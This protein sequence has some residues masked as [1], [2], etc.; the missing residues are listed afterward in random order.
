[1]WKKKR[2]REPYGFHVPGCAA[3]DAGLAGGNSQVED[4]ECDDA[5]YVRDAETAM[6]KNAEPGK[7]GEQYEIEIW[8]ESAPR[9]A[10]R[11]RVRNFAG[12][13]RVVAGCTAT[14]HHVSHRVSYRNV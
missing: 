12:S 13:K 2:G 8:Y 5:E 7:T 11:S 3:E 4:D 9:A 10:G 6:L 1:M 14:R